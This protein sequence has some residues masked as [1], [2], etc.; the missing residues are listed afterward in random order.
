MG[1]EFNYELLFNLSADLLCIAGYDGYFKKI[2][3]AVSKVLGYTMEELYS[4]PINDFVYGPDK[5]ITARVRKE[6]TRSVPLL[7]FEN[8]YLTKSGE[9]VWLSWTS[10]PVEEEKLIFAI[11]KDITHKKNLEEE[12]NLVLVDLAKANENLRRLNYTTSHDLR[13]P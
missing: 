8:R 7:N 5:E 1:N 3:P 2:N 6:L 11:A 9:I 10:M 4:R 12:R 13:S